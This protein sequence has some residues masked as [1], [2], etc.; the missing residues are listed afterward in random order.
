[1][2]PPFRLPRPSVAARIVLGVLAVEAVAVA[3]T[4]WSERAGLRANRDGVTFNWSVDTP[5]WRTFEHGGVIRPPAVPAERAELAGGEEVLGVVLGGKARAYRLRALADPTRHVVNDV[6]DGVPVSVTYCDLTDCARAFT[7]PAGDRPLD[8]AQAGL[9]GHEMV[10]EVAGVRYLHR[11]GV[12]AERGVGI[13][14]LPYPSLA[15]KRTTW[16][17]WR[18]LHPRGDVYLGGRGGDRDRDDRTRPARRGGRGPGR[19]GS[20]RPAAGLEPAGPAR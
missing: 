11:T 9:F 10:L 6:V 12:P 2:S 8:V 7:G 1:M 4:Y 3:S 19:V 17:E 14:P 16:D 13:P 20:R 5:S 18:R 15:L